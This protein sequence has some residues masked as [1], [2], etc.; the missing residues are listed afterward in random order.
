MFEFVVFF[1]KKSK[2]FDLPMIRSKHEEHLLS[3]IFYHVSEAGAIRKEN[4]MPKKKYYAPVVVTSWNK[5]PPLLTIDEAA[6]ILR[7][8]PVTARRMARE[9]IIKAGKI[10]PKI[11]RVDR[12]SLREYMGGVTQ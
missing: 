9:G 1:I 2:H 4:T 8:A 11:W 5:L 7:I 10:G 3:A 12:D 6:A